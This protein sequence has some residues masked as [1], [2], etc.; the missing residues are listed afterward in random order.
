MIDALAKEKIIN[1]LAAL[2][3]YGLTNN[4][5]LTAIEEIIS[6]SDFVNDL[7]RCDFNSQDTSYSIKDTYSLKTE[8]KSSW[9][10]CQSLFM[11]MLFMRI[12]KHHIRFSL[13]IILNVTAML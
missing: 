11:W 3:E 8:I 4:Y 10:K 13:S 9:K 1:K 12:A 5:S 6:R 7:E 2:L